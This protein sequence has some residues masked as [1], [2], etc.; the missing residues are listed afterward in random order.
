MLKGIH[1]AHVLAGTGACFIAVSH[2]VRPLRSG[3]RLYFGQGF[4]A[5]LVKY[6]TYEGIACASGV[7]GLYGYAWYNSGGV[8]K[9]EHGTFPA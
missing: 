4:I 3:E 6:S 8:I 5:K 9:A 2:Y 7:Y 1:S